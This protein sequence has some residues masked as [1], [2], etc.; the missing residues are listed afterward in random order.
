MALKQAQELVERIKLANASLTW[1]PMLRRELAGKGEALSAIDAVEKALRHTGG[2]DMSP[3]RRD[4]TAPGD[5]DDYDVMAPTAFAVLCKHGDVGGARVLAKTGAVNTNA[6]LDWR[7]QVLVMDDAA[8][9]GLTSTQIYLDGHSAEYCDES[10]SAG[11]R[12]HYPHPPLNQACIDGDLVMVRALLEMGADINGTQM[13]HSLEPVCIAASDMN[14]DPPRL[15]LEF[16]ADL[17]YVGRDQKCEKLPIHYVNASHPIC[18]L[19]LAAG[20]RSIASSDGSSFQVDWKPES[21]IEEYRTK[22]VPEI[23]RLLIE[24]RSDGGGALFALHL[25]MKCMVWRLAQDVLAM[26]ALSTFDA[27]ER[28]FEPDRYRD[29]PQALLQHAIARSGQLANKLSYHNRNSSED[30]RNTFVTPEIISFATF[31]FKRRGFDPNS[32]KSG[33]DTNSVIY[34]VV[35]QNSVELL[36]HFLCLGV[37]PRQNCHSC[38]ASVTEI[39]ANSQH[40]CDGLFMQV[41]LLAAYGAKLC[42]MHSTSEWDQFQKHCTAKNV[43]A[44]NAIADWSKEMR[45]W[46]PLRVAV[47]SGLP[48]EST[49]AL[50]LGNF[51]PDQIPIHFDRHDELEHQETRDLA[52]HSPIP[53]GGRWV[54]NVDD[55]SDETEQLRSELVLFARL[56]T[57]GWSPQAHW[58][59]HRGVRDAIKVLLLISER[60]YQNSVQP[61]LA[62]AP[63][64][65]GTPSTTAAP[66]P[67]QSQ[68]HPDDQVAAAATPLLPLLPQEMWLHIGAFFCRSFWP[69]PPLFPSTA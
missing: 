34:H 58:L 27:Y 56:A 41:L 52:A 44:Y 21:Y 60:L 36:R 45:D 64:S 31:L 29:P 51:D 17:N 33:V 59:H 32:F 57:S 48:K 50:R 5:N 9:S 2:C 14:L 25:A 40:V 13:A 38:F 63:A 37:N 20:G 46:S 1:L 4:V 24:A 12:H 18:A 69:V 3:V 28:C 7:A 47:A 65:G 39:A 53:W 54:P 43:A 61:E 15:L 8:G 22:N 42:R 55:D 30:N 26:P 6:K 11:D 16:D 10:I 66:D 68:H 23:M 35:K 19:V 49:S 62:A 67:G